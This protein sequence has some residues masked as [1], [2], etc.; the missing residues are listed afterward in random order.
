MI[1]QRFLF[2][3]IIIFITG[4]LSVKM[5]AAQK[6]YGDAVYLKNGS[7]ITGTIIQNDSIKG[8]KIANDCGIWFFK[9]SEYDSI[10]F[11]PGGKYYIAKNKGY[12]NLSSIGLL[13]GIDATPVA[14]VT[15][16]NGIKL[17]SKFSSGIGI[18]YEYFVWSVLPV[19]ADVR[20]Y[21][22]NK[23]FSPLLIG[24]FGYSVSLENLPSYYW[25]R[26]Y[27]KTFG[28]IMWSLGGGIRAGIAQKTAFIAGIH[29]RFQKLSRESDSWSPGEKNLIHSN[30]NRVAISIGFLFE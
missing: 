2:G 17:S 19:F 20:Y 12:F 29:Y 3:F 5:A 11:F 21:F 4:L 16:I 18:G 9:H 26:S 8:L 14:S 22:S 7:V 27:N 1:K 24:Q 25:D 23:G 28:G 13:F 15:M 6:L 10:G 30:Y